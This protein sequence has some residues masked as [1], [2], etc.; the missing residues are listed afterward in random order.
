MAGTQQSSNRERA[1]QF[2][3]MAE[4]DPSDVFPH[5]REIEKYVIDPD[6]G[7][8]YEA[9]ETLLKLSINYPLELRDHIP[10]VVSRFDDENVSVRVS[11]YTTAFNL[12][13]WFPQEFT[14]S[15]DLLVAA[16]SA[17]RE[18]ERLMGAAVIARIGLLRPDLVTPRDEAVSRLK[19][20]QKNDSF[21]DESNG[22]PIG[23]SVVE[24]AIRALKGGDLAS[25]PVEADLAP[26]A[27][28]TTLSKPFRVAMQTVF[29][30]AATLL[31]ALIGLVSALRF[32]YRYRHLSPAYRGRVMLS[33]TRKFTFFLNRR[34]A[35]LYLRSS[36]WPTA[37]Q[38]IP[39]LPGKAPISENSG[40]RTPEL[41][42]EWGRIASLVRQR[43]GFHCRNCGAGGGPNG[44]AELHVDHVIPRSRE[45]SNFPT[46]LRTLC[47]E[48]HEARH[49]RKF[50]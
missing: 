47:R 44:D 28:A 13:M 3:Q 20:L 8:R 27:R 23:S 24:D 31:S 26:T 7:T 22:I 33:Q 16:M 49:A 38:L 5:I 25:R 41:P 11:A 30:T 32:A 1:E 12:A 43:D 9:V 4:N 45:G 14:P 46:N 48:C 50:N 40:V 10:L 2:R 17:D 18:E 34:R 35:I 29:V 42:E 15:T 6:P 39:F 19:S 37:T 36:V 21:S